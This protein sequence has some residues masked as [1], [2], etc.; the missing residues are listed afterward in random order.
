MTKEQQQFYT[1]VGEQ[2][3]QSEMKEKIEAELQPDP[4]E[5]TKEDIIIKAVWMNTN[6]N[7]VMLVLCASTLVSVWVNN[8]AFQIV[9]FLFISGIGSKYLMKWNKEIK[10]LL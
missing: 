10:P 2:K 9:A 5:P 4:P 8:T 1:P 6:L 3:P 7:V